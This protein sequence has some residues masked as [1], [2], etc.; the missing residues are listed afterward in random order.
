MM[1][2]QLQTNEDRIL[3]LEDKAHEIQQVQQEELTADYD[4]ALKEY[5]TKNKPHLIKFAGEIFEIPREMPFKFATFYFR[6][7][8]KKVAGKTQMQVPE[9]KLYEF[10]ELMFG[11]KFLYTLEKSDAGMNFVFQKIV[12]DIMKMWGHD[13]DTSK[14]RKQQKNVR[15]RA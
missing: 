8:V 11:K 4:A 9:D 2:N 13:I 10:I 14:Q 7:C 12:P 6:H 3:F 1:S 5:E 15:T